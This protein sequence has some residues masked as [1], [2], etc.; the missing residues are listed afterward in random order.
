MIS[1]DL[2]VLLIL[3]T[4]SAFLGYIAFWRGYSK[5]RVEGREEAE[6]Y[7]DE[8]DETTRIIGEMAAARQRHPSH[9]LRVVRE[10]S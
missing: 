8:L 5:G 7:L 10:E 4:Y 1:P 2:I 9:G 6:R 3:S